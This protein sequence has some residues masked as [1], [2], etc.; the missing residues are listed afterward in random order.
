MYSKEDLLYRT[1]LIVTLIIGIIIVGFLLSVIT[2]QRKWR[3]LNL[4]KIE[5]EIDAIE[6]ERERLAADLHDEIGAGLTA[7]KFKLESIDTASSDDQVQ[8]FQCVH[9]V[10]DLVDRI[11]LITNDLMPLTLVNNGITDAVTEYARLVNVN[12]KLSITLESIGAADVP[13]SCS[14][15]IFRILQEIIHNTIKHAKASVLKIELLMETDKLIILTADNGQ[16]FDYDSTLKKKKGLGLSNL[17]NRADYLGGA[18]HLTSA[19]GKGT[20]CHIVVPL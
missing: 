7:M 14:R 15:H 16:G 3:K 8:V 20:R 9:L 12:S 6:N 18:F 17:Q 13:P 10:H 2:Q 4:K 19:R 11:R 1:I 5:T